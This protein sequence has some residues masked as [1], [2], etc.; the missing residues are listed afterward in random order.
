MR[1]P[2]KMP[3]G[4][5]RMALLARD[6]GWSVEHAR[7]GHLR[8]TSPEGRSVCTGAT[9][10]DARGWRNDVAKLRRAGLDDRRKTR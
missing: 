9:P 1:L 3:D 5:R 4:L 10:S 6:Q 8:W 7:S 2:R